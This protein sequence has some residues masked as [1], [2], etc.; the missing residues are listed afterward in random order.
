MANTKVIESLLKSIVINLKKYFDRIKTKI[1]E[2][3][4]VITEMG[5]QIPLIKNVANVPTA[6]ASI[7][8]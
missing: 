6:I 4:D 5:G 7:P 2:C 3:Y 1:I 8:A